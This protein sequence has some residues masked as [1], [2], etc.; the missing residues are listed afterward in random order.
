M[1]KRFEMKY[2]KEHYNDWYEDNK[3]IIHFRGK[4]DAI[5]AGANFRSKRLN[6]KCILFINGRSDNR[7]SVTPPH[8]YLGPVVLKREVACERLSLSSR[9]FDMAMSCASG[10]ARD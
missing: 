10:Q 5:L 1:W 2:S 3:E 6:N 4:D 7:K 8:L 9:R